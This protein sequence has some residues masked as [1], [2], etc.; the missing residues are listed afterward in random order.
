MKKLLVFFLIIHSPY[1]LISQEYVKNIK[2]DVVIEGAFDSKVK[3]KSGM[4]FLYELLGN[5]EY[6]LDSVQVS[7]GKFLFKKKS[8]YTGVYRLGFNNSTNAL[9]FVINPSELND[10]KISI[11][12]NNYRIKNGYNIPNSV[13]NR[14]KKLYSVKE[15]SINSKLKLIKKSQKTCK[16]F[17][18]HLF[19]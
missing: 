19:K 4:L 1:F 12:I 6:I 14:I 8:Y 13:E 7:N 2:G 18:Y 15:E 9:D 10:G 5:D 17:A 16:Y 11:K 3:S